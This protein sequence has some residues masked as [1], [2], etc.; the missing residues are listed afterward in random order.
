MAVEQDICPEQ[1]HACRT[2]PA[3]VMGDVPHTK[4]SAAL[5]TWRPFGDGGIAARPAGAL[6]ETAQGVEGDHHKQAD[7]ARAHAGAK[8]EHT[9]GGEDQ[10]KRQELL[11]VFTVGVIGDQ[12]FA[13][14]VSDRETEANHPQLRHAQPVGGDHVVLGDVEVFADQVHGQVADEH[15][16]I[17]LHER[18]E[19][20][21]APHLERQIQGRLA[22]LV[23]KG[24]HQKLLI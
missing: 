2:C 9:D 13:D 6:E 15:H 7:G 18:L 17:G 23:E 19:P 1:C 14:T 21:F 16:Q 5:A 4:I 20:H 22:H 3:E 8:A 10:H 12:G 11:G 24:Q